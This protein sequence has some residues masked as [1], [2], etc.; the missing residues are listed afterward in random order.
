MPFNFISIFRKIKREPKIRQMIGKKN[1]NKKQIQL[2]L[3]MFLPMASVCV[4]T[5]TSENY[6]TAV[7]SFIRFNGGADILLTLINADMMKQY[8]LWLRK[9]GVCPN[10]SSCYMRSLRAIYNKAVAKR[11]IPDKKPFNTVFSGNEKT[12]KRSVDVDDIR[13]IKSL[14]LPDG[15]VQA[16]TRDLFLFSFYAMGMPFIDMAYLKKSRI[17]DDFLTYYRHKTGKQVR[18]KLE[19]CMS[20]IISKYEDKHTDYIFPIICITNK[21]SKERSYG[22]ALSCYNRTLKTLSQK[23]GIKRKL[24]SYVARHSWASIAY[25]KN[26]ELST[27]SKALG[28]TD[29]QATL[30]YINDIN[31]TQLTKANKKILKEIFPPLCKR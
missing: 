6:K 12:Q 24:T 11:Q 25:G 27:I 16:L 9:S 21:Q 13:R 17:K 23:A 3:T 31:D 4:S 29:T 8:E 20:D 2:T 1:V 26:I 19:K 22:S 5:S 7:R 30:I 10:T 28:H 18:I 14:S 15:S